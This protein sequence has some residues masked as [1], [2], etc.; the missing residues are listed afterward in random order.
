MDSHHPDIPTLLKDAGLRVTPQREA[1]LTFLMEYDGHATV[2][3]IYK[4]IH[5]TFPSM[6]MS[7]VYNTVKHF[8]QVGLVKEITFG[9]NASRF[10]INVKP[11]HHLV[12]RKCGALIDFYMDKLP[13]FSLPPEANGFAIEDYHVEV[14]GICPSCQRASAV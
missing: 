6:S 7:T 13:S 9:D 3:E 5:P 8:A 11:H 12:C 1:I 2:D 14:K 10:D 4:A